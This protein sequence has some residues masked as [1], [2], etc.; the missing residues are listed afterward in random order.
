MHRGTRHHSRHRY[1]R[2]RASRIAGVSAPLTIRRPEEPELPVSSA[3]PTQCQRPA[4]GG[5]PPLREPNTTCGEG[6]EVTTSRLRS[7][8]ADVR[9]DSSVNR[10]GDAMSLC[11]KQPAR[12]R[13][14]R[15][16]PSRI[17]TATDLLS[18]RILINPKQSR[19]ELTDVSSGFMHQPTRTPGVTPHPKWLSQMPA[20]Q[21]LSLSHRAPAELSNALRAVTCTKPRFSTKYSLH[22]RADA[23]HATDSSVCSE[24]V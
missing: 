23:I 22:R 9:C 18:A 13:Y 6:D 3:S 4:T 12:H 10:D 20:H 16:R 2:L 24:Q 14:L 5:A 1:P 21:Y 19:L 15:P 8:C 11:V 7:S 17:A